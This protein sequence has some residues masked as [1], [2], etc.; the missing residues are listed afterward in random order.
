MLLTFKN[1]FFRLYQTK[2]H[3]QNFQILLFSIPYS[4]NVELSLDQI[5]KFLFLILLLRMQQIQIV[6]ALYTFRII[7]KYD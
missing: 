4:N 3:S 7:L 5:L 1:Y 6:E 2:L